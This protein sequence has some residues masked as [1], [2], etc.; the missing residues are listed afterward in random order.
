MSTFFTF[1]GDHPLL[2][3][4]FVV[5]LILFIWNEVKRGGKTIDSQQLVSMMNKDEAV[6]LDV[7]DST[8]FSKGHINGAVNIPFAALTNRVKEL[9]KYRSQTVVIAC[10]MGQHSGLATNVL[11]KEGFEDVAKLRGGL[12]EWRAQNMPVVK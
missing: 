1:L 2:V 6:V 9:E 11:R 5:I 12:M 7:R 8:E 3:G 4:A 10:K